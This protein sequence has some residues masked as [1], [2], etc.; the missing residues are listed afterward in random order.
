MLRFFKS[1]TASGMSSSPPTRN[2]RKVSWK[3]VNAVPAIFKEISI[4]PKAM[5]VKTIHNVPILDDIQKDPFQNGYIN[6]LYYI[7]IEKG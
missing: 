4:V 5:A 6:T 1:R 2:R 7:P 3:G